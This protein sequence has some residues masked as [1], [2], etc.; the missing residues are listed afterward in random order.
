MT[1]TAAAPAAHLHPGYRTGLRRLR[2]V[3][4]REVA[5]DVRHLVLVDPAGGPLTGYEPGSHL[6]VN[7]GE[8]GEQR[9]NAYSLLDDGVNPRRYTISV[10]RR[11]RGGG[12]DWLHDR[13][14]VGEDLEIEGPRSSFAPRHDQR[15]ALLVAGGIG[16]TPVLSHARAALR[17]GRSA[18]IVYAHRPGRGAHL[19]E[20]RALAAEGAITLHE[21]DS[22]AE[23]RELLAVRLTDQPLGTHAYACGPI[24]ML[25]TFLEL[26]QAAGWPADRLHVERFEAPRLDPGVA[27]E[28]TLTST[29]ERLRVPPGVSLLQSLL[30]A[31]RAVSSLCRQGVC[32]E[33]VVPVRAGAIE[34]RDLVL[35]E[36]EK[37]AGDVVISCVSRAAGPEIEVDL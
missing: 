11:G 20:V 21:A 4:A 34:H 31:G 2:V 28:V 12:S 3:E 37:A 10:L 25:E 23:A 7:A 27:F 8:A 19:D 30:D 32:G 6:V 33:C 18:E 29:G 13:L 26:G 24:A 14:A 15:N 1:T 5:P 35:T 9:R 22:A 16:I 17:W 36:A